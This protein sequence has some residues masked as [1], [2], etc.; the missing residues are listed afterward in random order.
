MKRKYLI[1]LLINLFFLTAT[2]TTYSHCCPLVIESLF[3]LDSLKWEISQEYHGNNE[4]LLELC[5]KNK[6][7][8]EKVQFTFKEF[9][10]KK[11]ESN[12]ITLSSLLFP[13][14]ENI[15]SLSQMK[16]LRLNSKY[17]QSPY[18]SWKLL[19]VFDENDIIYRCITPSL[20]P[21]TSLYQITRLIKKENGFISIT[22][23]TPKP[24][25]SERE[26]YWF[27]WLKSLK[28]S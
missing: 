18:M 16:E 5:S 23:E 13:D 9:T 6:N 25:L 1:T 26:T 20:G 14:Y 10:K 21:Y 4:D 17:K 22:Y 28:I 7:Y 11:I 3:S 24:P 2:A 8:P 19:Y 12:P 27:S 15:S